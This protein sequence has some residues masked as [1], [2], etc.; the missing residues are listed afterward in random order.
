[1]KKILLTNNSLV[2]NLAEIKFDKIY[3]DSP[4]VVENY[5]NAIYLDTLLDQNFDEIVN[6]I[7]KKG[8]E[9]NKDII[10]KFFPKYKNRN[11]DILNI[12]IEFTNIFIGI[13]KLIRLIDLHSNDEITI[14]ISNDEL[15]NHNSPEVLEGY[16]NRFTNIYYWITDLAKIKN[17]KLLCKNIK[18]DLSL[19]HTVVDSWF[20]RLIDLDKKVLVFNFLKKIGL[21]NKN[22]K[23]IYKYK[24]SNAIREIEPYLHKLGFSLID[25]PE[26][27]FK[28]ENIDDQ[29][30]YESL[31]DILD[32]FFE[33]NLLNNIFKAVIYKMYKKRIK[34]Y[35]Q[36]EK[37]TKNYISKLDKSIKVIVTNTIN[38]FESGIFAKQLQENGYKIVN[39]THSFSINFKRKQDFDFF[40][41][42][43]PDMTLCFN[44]SESELYKEL[45]PG[46]LVQH[47]SAPQ[48][49]KNKRLGFLKRLIVNKM[50]KL[51]EDKNIF[52]PSMIYPLNNVSTYGWRLPDKLTYKFEKNM[53]KILSN[54]NKRA[55]YKH[56]PMRSFIDPNSI[57]DYAK[58]FKNIKVIHERYDFR[59]VSSVGDIFILGNIGAASG[60]KWMLGENKPIVFLYT[61]TFRFINEEG[62]KILE[63]GFIVVD[64][65]NANWVD[66]LTSILNKP[67]KELMKIWKD[68]KIYRDQ[69]DEEWF[70]GTNLHAGKIGSK[71]I[72][73]LIND[74]LKNN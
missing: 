59:F 52:Y 21:I 66:N 49:A 61:N 19:G 31:N 24:K 58:G 28:Y 45:V 62:K 32:K 43:A 74:S 26:I 22:K 3:T 70:M 71:Y 15:Y 40:E 33:K 17:V 4:F 7:R 47:I 63:K 9:I 53:I 51:S 23:K 56:Y 55:I 64:I 2:A 65:D 6:N 16:D 27:K 36:M 48:E 67:Y 5:N 14:G 29:I 1:M 73:K 25:M 11:I 34:Y 57:I 42:Q 60:L 39:V 50:L 10:N 72:N 69:Y 30:K 35:S 41:S 68:K 38:G 18:N 54:V 13:T 20:L 37:Y 46:T 12:N 8:Y 44:R